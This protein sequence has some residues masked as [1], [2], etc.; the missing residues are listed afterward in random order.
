MTY[1][2][3]RSLKLRNLPIV[4]TQGLTGKDKE[5]FENYLKNSVRL[6]DKL[7][8]IVYKKIETLERKQLQDDFYNTPELTNR[9]CYLNGQLSTLNYILDLIRFKEGNTNG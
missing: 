8:E 7:E 9:L 5:D 1:Q 4:W 3:Q 6:L 2:F